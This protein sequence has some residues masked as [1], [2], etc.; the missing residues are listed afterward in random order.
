[1][2][3]WRSPVHFGL[4]RM[5]GTLYNES[6]VTLGPLSL[7]FSEFIH[8][9]RYSIPPLS[10]TKTK[11]HEALLH[12]P[13]LYEVASQAPLPLVLRI[14][15]V[16]AEDQNPDLVWGEPRRLKR[17]FSTP[18]SCR[19]SEIARSGSLQVKQLTGWKYTSPE[20]WTS[21]SPAAEPGTAKSFME[22]GETLLI[23]LEL[24]MGSTP[25]V[26]GDFEPRPSPQVS[27]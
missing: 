26:E 16:M 25:E 1:M 4:K 27:R 8:R 22:A 18:F 9:N 19:E 23:P 3:P 2:Y 6:T 14:A 17:P 5:C 15:L 13:D 10:K 21:I 11:F 7:T 12:V 24:R 20:V